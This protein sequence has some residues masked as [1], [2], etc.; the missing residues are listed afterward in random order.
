MI[1]NLIENNPIAMFQSFFESVRNKK[2]VDKQASF[3]LY[4]S[5][6]EMFFFVK[7]I[8]FVF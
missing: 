7:K 1:Y 3:I 5:K 6:A 4:N 2:Y 8:V